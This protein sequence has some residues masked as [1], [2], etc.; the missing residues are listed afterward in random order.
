MVCRGHR[1]ILM[2]T[3]PMSHLQAEV[4]VFF[5][6]ILLRSIEP[7]ATGSALPAQGALI[8]WILILATQSPLVL[9]AMTCAK[10]RHVPRTGLA[11]L[12]M[13]DGPLVPA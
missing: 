12:V 7:Q 8:A 1:C 9:P 10:V 5:P 6:M 11:F 3:L 4:G 2:R 13:F